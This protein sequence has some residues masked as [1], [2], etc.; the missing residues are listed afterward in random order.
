MHLWFLIDKFKNN[1]KYIYKFI[2][3]YIQV[4]DKVVPVLN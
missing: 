4:K 2:Y 3:E 1:N